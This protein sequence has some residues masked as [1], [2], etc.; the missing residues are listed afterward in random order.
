MQCFHKFYSMCAHFPGPPEQR[1]RAC[2]PLS[3]SDWDNLVA[4]LK[5]QRHYENI[6]GGMSGIRFGGVVRRE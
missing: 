6:L 3:L 1:R 5:F 2:G 4:T